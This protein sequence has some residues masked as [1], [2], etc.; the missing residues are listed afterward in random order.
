MRLTFYLFKD[1]VRD[2]GSAV[3]DSTITAESA[4]YTRIDLK[5]E[6]PFE[7]E[8]FLQ[9][10]R[11]TKPKWLNF[12]EPFC[13]IRDVGDLRNSTCSFLLLIKA[14]DRIFAVTTGFGFTA[15]NRDLTERNFRLKV[16]LN[17]LEPSKIK[18][19]SARNV[20]V[21][22]RQTST[23]VSKESGIEDFRF[24]TDS[25]L[26]GAI[27]GPVSIEE[28]GK[29]LSGSDSLTLTSDAGFP[30]LGS[31]C[32]ILLEYFSKDTY[33]TN[34]GFIDKIV[35]IRD[36][37][38]IG[39]LVD[40][41]RESLDKRS[42][43]L[44]SIAP[45]ET[46][47][48][49]RI[50]T[51]KLNLGHKRFTFED[52]S[53]EGIYKEIGER[54]LDPLKSKV[55]GLDYDGNPCTKSTELINYIVFQTEHDKKT[56][57]LTLGQWYQVEKDYI[58]EVK[59][60]VSEFDVL[61]DLLPDML[62]GEAEGTYNKGVVE[63]SGR[64]LV[65]LDKE[66]VHVTGKSSV[67]V[68]D[69]LSQDMKFVCVKKWD[70]SSTLSH[71]FSQGSVSAELLGEYSEYRKSVLALVPDEWI[72]S[73][74]ADDIGEKRKIT[75]VYAIAYPERKPFE[76]RLPFFS[77]VNLVRNVRLIRSMGYSVAIAR[78][79]YSTEHIEDDRAEAEILEQTNP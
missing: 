22:T 75:F 41:L 16:A 3:K 52:L 32:E 29:R 18:R 19:I 7:A 79:G 6:V 50:E 12:V 54:E 34:F 67:E 8:A 30:E 53:L 73:F 37:A 76:L 24:D 4:P 14:S 26:I 74:T 35:P 38:L 70:S 61:N 56:F 28:I 66:L 10:N 69:I 36:K 15:I 33:R 9:R 49:D 23:Y 43:D 20:D 71:L 2:F 64:S 72:F 25:D 47:S 5:G 68:C 60:Y 78:I 46:D 55:V 51:Y 11:D 59:R 31:K 63:A 42:L 27:A 48:E 44:I 1:S 65:L 45:P 21:L 62:V 58:E 17:S 77:L 39:L 13:D 40:N 57:M